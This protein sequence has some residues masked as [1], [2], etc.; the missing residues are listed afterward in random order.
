MSGNILEEEDDDEEEGEGMSAAEYERELQCKK[1]AAQRWG[2]YTGKIPNPPARLSS[3]F[4]AWSSSTNQP[5][6]FKEATSQVASPV[7][8]ESASLRE[9]TWLSSQGDEE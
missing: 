8:R 4:C 7:K 2:Q 9:E 1:S 6:T 3:S 5:S